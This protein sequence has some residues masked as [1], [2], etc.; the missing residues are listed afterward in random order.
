MTKNH[1]PSNGLRV[2]L[3][4]GTNEAVALDELI[5]DVLH[6][7]MNG[8]LRALHEPHVEKLAAPDAPAAS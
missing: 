2:E 6:G 1:V 7:D 5:D 4:Q 8:A 3:N